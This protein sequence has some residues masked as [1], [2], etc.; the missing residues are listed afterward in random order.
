M[1]YDDRP[2]IVA[3]YAKEFGDASINIAGMQIARAAAGGKALSVL[4]IDS[5]APEDLLERV[6]VAISADL[7]VEIDMTD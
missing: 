2:G 1:V 4:M 6:R 7:L 3:I 5:P